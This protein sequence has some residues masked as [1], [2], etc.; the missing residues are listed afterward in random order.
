MRKTHGT[1]IL[2]VWL[3]W[4]DNVLQYTEVAKSNVFQYIVKPTWPC[5][6]STG[7]VRFS[8]AEWCAFYVL[9]WNEFGITASLFWHTDVHTKFASICATKVKQM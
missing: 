4:F 3:S 9:L 1:R 2:S 7:A 6:E 8:Q 5:R